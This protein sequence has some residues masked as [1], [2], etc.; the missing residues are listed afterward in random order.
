MAASNNIRLNPL[1]DRPVVH[2][3]AYVD[4]SAQVIGKVFLAEDVYVGP[5]AVV[6][7]DEVGP[8][9]TVS[10]VLV[11]EG[12][13]VQDGVIIH[14]SGGTSVEIGPRVSL[15]H[16]VIIHGPCIIGEGSFLAMRTTVYKATLQES[17]WVGMGSIIMRATV[18]SHTMIPANTVIRTRLDVHN[19]RLINQKEI[20]YIRNVLD[21]SMELRRGYL[22][23]ESGR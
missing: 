9:G 13:N 10:P 3:T 14:A 8:E 12:A 5:N 18:P 19:F 2:P 1:K 7:A 22:E 17:V 20:T 16:G 11:K 6:R 21:A 15:A 4:P 23:L